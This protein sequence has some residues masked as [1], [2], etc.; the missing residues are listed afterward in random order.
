MQIFELQ[1]NPNNKEDKLI[2]TFSYQPK[3]VYEKRL[4]ALIIGGEFK[5][6]N[7]SQKSFLNNLAHKIKNTYHSLPTRTQEEALKEGLKEANNFLEKKKIKENLHLAVLS[8]KDNQLQLSRIGNLKILLARNGEITDIGKNVDNNELTFGSIVTGKIRKNDKLIILTEEIYK[9]FLGEDL[10]IDLAD[11]AP[12]DKKKL[13]KISKIQ[14]EKFPKKV[15]VCLLIDFSFPSSGS[16]KIVSKDEFSFKKFSVNLAAESKKVLTLLWGNIKSELMAFRN[17]TKKNSKPILHNFVQ[18][19]IAG[20]KE[21]QKKCKK[22]FLWSKDNFVKLKKHN[23]QKPKKEKDNFNFLVFIKTE[24]KAGWQRLKNNLVKLK[25]SNYLPKFKG[26]KI[27]ENKEKRRNLY[28]A[29]LLFFIILIGASVTHFEKTKQLESQKKLLDQIEQSIAHID[30]H[31]NNFSELK[32]YYEKLNELIDD[33][34][35]LKSKAQSLKNEVAEKLLQISNTKIID[36]PELLFTTTEIIPSKMTLVGNEIYLYN[37]FLSNAEKYDLDAKEKLI[38]PVQIEDGGIFALASVSGIPYFFSKPDKLIIDNN[39]YTLTV[40]F[41]EYSYQQ[42]Q[43]W[44]EY[45]YLLERK[46]NQI[47]RYH[48]DNFADPLIWIE[49]RK[50]GNITA[51][52][53]D[54]SIWTLQEDNHIWRYEARKPLSGSKIIYKEIFPFPERFTLIKTSPDLPLFILEPKNN[55][56]IISTKEGDLL[57]QLLI[58]RAHHLKDFIPVREEGQ[59]K[60][61]L[62]DGQ[63][64]YFTTVEF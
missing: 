27:P 19:V 13:E 60:I 45:I 63:E 32:K 48:K 20:S 8:I 64:V 56:I 54:G 46:N 6:I 36:D 57:Y 43:S 1:F 47:V 34:M 40:P 38:K 7:A 50:P 4:G 2:D 49:E 41:S 51:F 17:W 59:I 24:S 5:L 53:I 58:P 37:P 29:G 44:G 18:L 33:R 28:L 31:A 26:F 11:T 30:P 55:R 9:K 42:L 10:L 16:A 23:T 3:D 21:I 39:L 15:G 35:V 12:I 52:A 22:L 25:E 14:K 62:L 61:Y